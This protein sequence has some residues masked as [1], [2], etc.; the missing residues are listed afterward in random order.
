MFVSSHFML[1]QIDVLEE[2]VK[3][4]DSQLSQARIRLTSAFTSQPSQGS[5]SALEEDLKEKDRQIDR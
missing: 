1:C 4:K 5:V 3:D 2:T